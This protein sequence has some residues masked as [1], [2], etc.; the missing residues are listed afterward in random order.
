MYMAVPRT[1]TNIKQIAA[2]V[3]KYVPCYPALCVDSRVILFPR[4]FPWRLRGQQAMAKK[5]TEKYVASLKAVPK[6]MEIPDGA[7]P[8]LYLRVMPSGAKSWAIRYRANGFHRRLTLGRYPKMGL[9][10]A[11]K[12][13]AACAVEVEKGNDPQADRSAR[14]SVLPRNLKG[15][16]DAYID[17]YAKV[18]TVRW[19]ETKRLFEIHVYPSWGNRS[20]DS[21]KRRDVV[22]LI[23]K[24]YTTAPV[25]SNRLLAALRHFFNWCVSRDA[26]DISP[27]M[28]VKTLAP[29]KARE[30]VLSD[31]E[32]GI[33]LI[34]LE[35]LNSR[36]S[37]AFLLMLLT[38]T[39]RTEVLEMEWQEVD[40][41]TATWTI[42]KHRTK[43]RALPNVVPLS[44]PAL[45]ILQR[46]EADRH[47][48]L[49]FPAANNSG[50]AMS[51]AS[52]A[53]RALDAEMLA[54]LQE[55]QAAASSK[56]SMKLSPMN[57]PWRL[58]DLRRTC[59]TALQRL[60]VRFE[61]TE[62]VLH[63]V[64]GARGGV[65]GIYQQH[66]WAPERREALVQWAQMVETIKLDAENLMKNSD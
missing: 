8:G 64:S 65:A 24:V 26:L 5:L 11:R 49:V 47:S 16:V 30:R 42:P 48:S 10:E 9:A 22:A 63:H 17:G 27:A 25:R 52:K 41:P 66:D 36:F 59:A 58:H 46:L 3:R 34:A 32:L 39:R 12:A 23:E 4:L 56:G 51:G 33:L 62:A 31:A 20:I 40:L 2:I 60:G 55:M 54:V 15:A 57:S 21:I 28:G 29:E 61:V 43:K 44:A 19:E 18:R 35:R 1:P 7:Y 13:A 14:Y 50:N 38:A 6:Q 45:A 53:K 37:D